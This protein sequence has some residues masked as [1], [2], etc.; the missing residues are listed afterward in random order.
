MKLLLIGPY[1]P[2]HGGISVH[3]AEAKKYLEQAG[4]QVRVLNTNC[5][6][7]QSEQYLGYCN[8]LGFAIRL[9]H[10]ARCG[11]T[12]HLH[13]NGHN[14][15]SWLTALICGMVG[16]F[17]PGCLLTLHSGMVPSYLKEVP[18]W[19]RYVA[20]FTCRFY[21]RVIA[22][23]SEIQNALV[24]VGV[25][26]EQVEVLPAYLATFP[27]APLSVPLEEFFQSHWPVLTTVLFY[28]TEY[29]FELLVEALSKLRKCY[30]NLGCLVMG[31]GE[32]QEDARQHVQQERIEDFV[33]LLGDVPHELCLALIS[34]SDIF[35]RCTLTDGDAI[36]VREAL[37]FGVP[38][39]ASDVGN[40]PPG[41]QLFQAGN[42]AEMI[43]KV[44][45]ALREPHRNSNRGKQQAAWNG[46]QRLLEMY[47]Q[48]FAEGAR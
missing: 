34:R 18:R 26:K 39:V 33:R 7:P 30:P 3:V 28:R 43:S 38:A 25:S 32:Q 17:G 6:A 40:R 14:P 11:W 35:V 16:K 15:K 21:D 42:V 19:Q 48:S 47:R 36:S 45:T 9:I 24:R 41:A 10:H 23:N 8:S 44:E 20:R 2:P 22:V 5:R 37:S 27:P 13:T 4:L 1:P 46:F 29:G 12:F 31:S